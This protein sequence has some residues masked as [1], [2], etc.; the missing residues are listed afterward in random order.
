MPSKVIRAI[1]AALTLPAPVERS[2][3]ACAISCERVGAVALVSSDGRLR[4][5]W[6]KPVGTKNGHSTEQCTCSLTRPRSWY[7]VS[8]SETT[9]CLVMLYTPIAG[10]LTSPAI[11]AVLTICAS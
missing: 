4:L 6:L 3:V 8:L 10:A 7:S 2:D 1:S 9:A 5:D 11:D